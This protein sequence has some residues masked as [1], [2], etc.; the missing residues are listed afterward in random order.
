VRLALLIA[1]AA[2]TLAAGASPAAADTGECKGFP[3]C[4]P[5]AGP[6]VVVPTANTVPR[7]RVEYELTCPRGFIVGGLDAELTD[8]QI[9][10]AFLGTLGT[11]VNPGIT[12]ARSAV[13]VASWVGAGAGAQTF[14]PHIGCIPAAGG[15]RRIPTSATRTVPPGQPTVRRTRTVRI[16]AGRTRAVTVRCAADERLVDASHALGFYTRTPPTGGMIAAASA[17]QRIRGDAVS[18]AARGGFALA[19]VRAVVQVGAVCAGGT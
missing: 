8:R 11:P 4:V 12:T 18:V 7:P 1:L 15:G 19:S 17:R 3:V 16:P 13:F 9:D 6:W 2:A 5:V 10:L 14:R